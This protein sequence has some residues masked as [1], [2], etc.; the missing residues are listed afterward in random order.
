VSL[1]E[2]N[3]VNRKT[4]QGIQRLLGRNPVPYPTPRP[5]RGGARGRMPVIVKALS[6]T[7]VGGGGIGDEAYDAVMIAAYG[8]VVSASQ[9]EQ[10]AV[11]LT[12]WGDALSVETPT[13]DGIYHGVFAGDFDPDPGGAGTDNRPRVFAVAPPTSGGGAALVQ[14][15]STNITAQIGTNTP[16]TYADIVTGALTLT[17]LG[18]WLITLNIGAVIHTTGGITV[19]SSVDVKVIQS[20]GDTFTLEFPPVMSREVAGAV[21]V[22]GYGSVSKI[23]TLTQTTVLKIQ[24][25][26]NAGSA[27]SAAGD[28]VVYNTDG[29]ALV[30]VY[31]GT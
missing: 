27:G 3:L 31:L 30:A 15:Y 6:D 20:S 11:W 19:P 10:T 28:C 13:E 17:T 5:S 4:A 2:E 18:K 22:D 29:N 26:L 24:A 23:L 7:A 16:G 14:V 25:E 9:P 12:I 1:Q 8:T 21:G